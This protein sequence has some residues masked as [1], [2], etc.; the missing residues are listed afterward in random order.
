MNSKSVDS[1][2]EPDVLA[3]QEAE[4]ADGSELAMEPDHAGME[5][6]MTRQSGDSSLYRIYLSSV[7]FLIASVFI[8]SVIVMS[9]LA[10]IPR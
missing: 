4:N 1:E 6:D 2:V 10:Q 9:G 3:P 7:G 8:V 5:Q